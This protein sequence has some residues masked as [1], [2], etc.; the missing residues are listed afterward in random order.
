M[1]KRPEFKNAKLRQAISMAVDRPAL[2]NA[3]GGANQ[4]AKTLTAPG[5]VDIKGKDYVDYVETPKSEAYMKHDAKKARELYKEALKELGKTSLTF[6]LL[7]YDDD[8]SKKATETLQS[9]LEDTLKD[10]NVHVQNIPKKTAIDKMVSGNFDVS[11]SG[12]SGD[13]ADPITF[14]DLLTPDNAMNFGK[15]DNE[16]YN[17]LLADSKNTGD[18]NKR[19]HDLEDAEKILLEEQGVSP[20]FHQQEAW[21]VKPS[22]KGVIYNGAGASYNFKHAYVAK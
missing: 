10:V 12:W 19:N 7:G 20:L 8:A 11:F 1:A 18:V 15:S 17:S 6:N 13:F 22:V 2:A 21:M 14:L 16:K 4:V 5:I 9:Q 3:L